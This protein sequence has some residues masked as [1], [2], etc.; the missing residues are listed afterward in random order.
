[1]LLG[2][3]D[4]MAAAVT[5]GVDEEVRDDAVEHEPIGDG[6]EIDRHIELARVPGDEGAARDLAEHACELRGASDRPYRRRV[7]AREVEQLLKQAAEPLAL[8]DADPEQLVA[9]LRRELVAARS[10]TS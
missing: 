3:D 9:Q 5:R 8:L 2:R 10:R 1:M 6:R 7:E 4:G